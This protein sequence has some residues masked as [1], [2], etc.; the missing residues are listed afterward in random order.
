MFKERDTPMLAVERITASRF[1]IWGG[2]MKYFKLSLAMFIGLALASGNL[3][4]QSDLPPGACFDLT[5]WTLQEPLGRYPH[6]P[7][8]IKSDKLSGKRGW[9]DSYFYYDQADSSITFMVPSTGVTTR[10]SLHVRCELREMN[11]NGTPAA[12]S[13]KTIHILRFTGSVT[14]LGGGTKGHTTL[15]Q[16]FDATSGKPLGELEWKDKALE[17]Y[18][19]NDPWG[20]S[21]KFYSLG[22]VRLGQRYQVVLGVVHNKLVVSVQGSGL[23]VYS[24]RKSF[25]SD[26]FY[27]KMGNYDQ[28]TKEGPVGTPYTVVKVYSFRLSRT[29]KSLR[30]LH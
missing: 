18:L 21:G 27:F 13:L 8:Q 11:K 12:W 22:S 14:Q 10:G 2:G 4:A 17:I 24:P 1:N 9:K 15:A 28:T 26:L 19:E 20:G 25:L 6:S 3:N 7:L 29:L 30:L 5:K 16:V 23:H